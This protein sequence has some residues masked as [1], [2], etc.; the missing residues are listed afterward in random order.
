MFTPSPRHTHWN[1][2]YRRLCAVLLSH[3]RKGS[4]GCDPAPWRLRKQ[5][6]WED[7]AQLPRHLFPKAEPKTLTGKLLSI[8]M[9]KYTFLLKIQT[10]ISPTSWHQLLCPTTLPH[11]YLLT[12]REILD[13][14]YFF[15]TSFLKTPC[16]M[17]LILNKFLCLSL[18]NLPFVWRLIYA[19]WNGYGQHIFSFALFSPHHWPIPSGVFIDINNGEERGLPS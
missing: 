4:L 10:R 15:G 17:Q 8:Y 7:H 6:E 9:N 12:Q 18:A 11:S 1:Y 5:Q 19:P 14:A 13:F 3:I 2:F 16:H